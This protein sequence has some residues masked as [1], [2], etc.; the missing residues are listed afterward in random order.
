MPPRRIRASLIVLL[1]L[2]TF[3]AACGA[4][5]SVGN[6]AAQPTDVGNAALVVAS[7]SAIKSPTDVSATEPN[8]PTSVIAEDAACDARIS[9]DF[10]MFTSLDELAWAS[11][12]VI[13]GTVAEILPAQ[14]IKVEGSVLPFTIVTDAMVTVDRQFRGQAATM[15]RVRLLGGS[16]GDCAQEFP[17]SPQLTPGTSV[18]L[19]LREP[20][21]ATS[22][23]A[24]ELTGGKQGYWTISDGGLVTATDPRLQLT[25]EA[26]TV[27]AVEGA[28]SATL[29][30]GPP[31]DNP[32]L[33]QFLVPVS[34]AP[35]ESGDAGTPTATP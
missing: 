13:E 26:A 28:L 20:D 17:D 34:E 31:A 14:K 25:G 33:D 3:A 4:P 7:P 8:D 18:L 23:Q 30:A 2:G 29:A 24:Y 9:E 6:G 12:Q 19:F 11:H 15:V 32:L 1:C 22:D 35:I 5:D 16:I 10:A 27:A 21:A